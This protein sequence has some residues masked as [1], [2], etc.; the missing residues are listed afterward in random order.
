MRRL[1]SRAHQGYVFLMIPD[2]IPTQ[3][4]IAL[5][6]LLRLQV[7]KLG[8]SFPVSVMSKGPRG[9]CTL[10]VPHTAP[11][12]RR[13]LSSVFYT[14]RSLCNLTGA[15]L[16]PQIFSPLFSHPSVSPRPQPVTCYHTT[17]FSSI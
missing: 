14:T 7:T 11:L 12:E 17:T 8:S 2:S 10:W 5:A 4:H 1:Q 15:V 16:D 6:R 3:R 9:G 13:W